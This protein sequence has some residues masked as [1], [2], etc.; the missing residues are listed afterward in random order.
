MIIIVMMVVVMMV[1]LVVMMMVVVVMI[2]V[3]MMVVVLMVVVVVL[4]LL[5]VMMMMVVV[6]VVV[7][8][9]MVVVVLMTLVVVVMMVLMVGDDAI[10]GG[11]DGGGRGALNWD[12]CKCLAVKVHVPLFL[13]NSLKNSP[14]LPKYIFFNTGS[15]PVWIL[16]QIISN[17]ETSTSATV[18]LISTLP[19]IFTS[20][21]F[22]FFSENVYQNLPHISSPDLFFV[23]LFRLFVQ[24]G[25]RQNKLYDLFHL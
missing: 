14:N 13:K 15:A 9:T 3:V 5:V 2:M 22:E 7:V 20:S 8:M 19:V 10:D 23:Y 1:V 11:D 16:C 21:F 4:L 25:V 6:V 12:M 17:R 18:W 24:S